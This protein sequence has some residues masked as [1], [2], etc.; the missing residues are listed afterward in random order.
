MFY[1]CPIPKRLSLQIVFRSS[2]C[3][4]RILFLPENIEA[5]H[6]DQ[7]REDNQGIRDHARNASHINIVSEPAGIADQI[8]NANRARIFDSE[9]N[10]GNKLRDNNENADISVPGQSADRHEHDGK[11]NLK[12]KRALSVLDAE[13]IESVGKAAC[14]IDAHSR[15]SAEQKIM[16]RGGEFISD[17][18]HNDM[19]VLLLLHTENNH[20]RTEKA[21][22][23]RDNL[24]CRHKKPS[25]IKNN[26][27][28]FIIP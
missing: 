20:D 13:I 10:G 9:R 2:A 26:Q 11:Q 19:L 24:R 25:E 23:L 16:N 22:H 17:L 21:D 3:H 5:D 8:K 12:G 28:A 18:A 14:E 15:P 27:T 6:R 7:N 4:R 1:Q